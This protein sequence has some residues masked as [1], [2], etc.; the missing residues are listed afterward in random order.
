MLVKA[1]D[2][3]DLGIKRKGEKKMGQSKRKK[4]S[5]REGMKKKERVWMKGEW[6][7]IKKKKWKKM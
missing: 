2:E 4:D 1:N 3:N 5:W 6:K 7:Q